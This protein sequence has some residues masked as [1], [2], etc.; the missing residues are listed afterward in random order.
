[1]ERGKHASEH[2]K[3]D[4][5]TMAAAMATKTVRPQVVLL[6]CFI[7]SHRTRV[8]DGL[9]FVIQVSLLLAS[10]AWGFVP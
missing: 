10:N 6:L 5:P 2:P 9:I 8:S 3:H 4:Q 7:I 1:M